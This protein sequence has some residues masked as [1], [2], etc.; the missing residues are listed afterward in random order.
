M[1]T[2]G[3]LRIEAPAQCHTPR[4]GRMHTWTHERTYRGF[5]DRQR[6]HNAHEACKSCLEDFVRLQT[7]VTD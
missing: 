3:A 2:I 5:D 4:I 7:G 6:L 1:P